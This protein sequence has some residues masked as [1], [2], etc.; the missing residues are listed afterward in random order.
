MLTLAGPDGL[1]GTDDERA[2]ISELAHR[3]IV[4][5]APQELLLFDET[6]A[7]Y[8]EDPKA[9]VKPR[10][11]DEAVGFGLELALLTPYVMAIAAAAVH[12]LGSI[13]MGAV[14]DE[15][16]VYA[17][18]LIRRLFRL[19]DPDSK[20]ATPAPAPLN[21]QQA[22]RV[23]EVALGRAR[24]LGLPEAQAAFL[25]DAITGGLLVGP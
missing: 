10:S 17:R 19:P 20:P 1:L 8:F 13:V 16:G 7:D 2:V 24:T 23:H 14:K 4:A 25:A 12:A 3:A 9:A 5:A 18:S 15:G 22:Q 6:A 21:L 11:R